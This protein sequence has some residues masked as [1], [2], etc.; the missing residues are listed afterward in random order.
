VVANPFIDPNEKHRIMSANRLSIPFQERCRLAGCALDHWRAILAFLSSGALYTVV[1]C[2]RSIWSGY[3]G[4]FCHFGLILGRHVRAD[5][6]WLYPGLRHLFMINFAHGEVM[7]LGA[8]GGY[9]V[10]EILEYSGCHC[11]RIPA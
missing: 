5:R 11:R 4:A 9:F 6:Y 7:M 3:L 2:Q 1:Y 8:F 10:F